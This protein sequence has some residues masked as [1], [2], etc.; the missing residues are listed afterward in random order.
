MII[1]C[2]CS[3]SA[4]ELPNLNYQ[5]WRGQRLEAQRSEYN[6]GLKLNC[7]FQLQKSYGMDLQP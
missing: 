4:A 7:D 3:L 6:H 2:L 1:V 5:L